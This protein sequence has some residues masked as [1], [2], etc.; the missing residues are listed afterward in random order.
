MGRVLGLDLGD[1]RIGIAMSDATRTLASGRD[2]YQRRSLDE[3]LE[4]LE[5]LV[6]EESIS[7]IVL[8]LPC[9]MDG[10]LG[11]RAQKTLR[12]KALLEEKL[13]LPVVLFD[14]RLTTE[15]AERVLLS[16][17]V[18]RKKRKRV[19]DQLAAVII[20]QRYLDQRE[21]SPNNPSCRP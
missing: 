5:K 20:L 13:K 4:H 17:D 21:K 12:F 1:R 16:A 10:T 15:E 8:G 7:E 3:D 18:S 14:E 2:V 9:N 11:E 19:I 6:K